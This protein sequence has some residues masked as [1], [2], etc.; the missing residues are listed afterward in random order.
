[1][2]LRGLILLAVVM[3]AG[4]IGCDVAPALTGGGGGGGDDG[5][6]KVLPLENLTFTAANHGQTAT[7]TI[8][9]VDA[10]A[11]Y[12]ARIRFVALRDKDPQYVGDGYDRLDVTLAPGQRVGF[13]V[14]VRT[15]DQ[16]VDRWEYLLEQI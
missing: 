6:K 3:L 16:K 4:M 10:V 13:S 11:H 1:M 12:L 15:N 9:N 14:F 2:K 5:L 8:H 7:G